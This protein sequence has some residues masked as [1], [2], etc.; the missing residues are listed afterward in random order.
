[1]QTFPPAAPGMESVPAAT[2][3][4]EQRRSDSNVAT[5]QLL[6]AAIATLAQESQGAHPASNAIA[7]QPSPVEAPVAAP[8][9]PPGPPP[10]GNSPVGFQTHG[11]WVAGV[12][13]IVVPAGPLLLITEDAPVE[14][15]DPPIW[16]SMTKGTYVGVHRSQ[17]LA[18]AAVQGV[19]HSTMKGY[20]TQALAV[21]AFNEMLQ[22][23]MVAIRS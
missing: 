3:T 1:M 20:K 16:Y 17:A 4:P 14:G 10:P 23:H 5:L 6:S 19:S 8:V 13:Y 7:S 22:Y 12:L 2:S 18:L 9:P 15:E 11:P 21:A